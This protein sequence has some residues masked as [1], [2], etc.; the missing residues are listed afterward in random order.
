[1]LSWKVSKDSLTK[2]KKSFV[3]RKPH[4]VKKLFSFFLPKENCL[5]FFRM[6]LPN[7]VF[8]LLILKKCLLFWDLSKTCQIFSW[9]WKVQPLKSTHGTTLSPIECL[10]HSF[11]SPS[12]LFW[13]PS[14]VVPQ[15]LGN[16]CVP[17]MVTPW[18]FLGNPSALVC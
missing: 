16:N 13:P 10:R 15:D 11:R 12:K 14:N 8:H 18:I 2:V 17:W 7:L 4:I 5:L 9:I 1:M 3:I 6:Y